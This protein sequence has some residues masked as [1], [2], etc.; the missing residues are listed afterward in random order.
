ME[1]VAEL[2]SLD[3]VEVCVLHRDTVAGRLVWD[4]LTRE[5]APRRR[6]TESEGP[7]TRFYVVQS[8]DLERPGTSWVGGVGLTGSRGLSLRR[9]SSWCE[10][11]LDAPGEGVV[12]AALGGVGHDH[13]AEVEAWVEAQE[14]EEAGAARLNCS[15]ARPAGARSISTGGGTTRSALTVSGADTSAPARR[16][17]R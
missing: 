5:D 10:G 6:R 15:A 3:V 17:H 9:H 14:V 13:D 7:K 8:S 4:L 1:Q 12:V 11:A 2:R 16:E